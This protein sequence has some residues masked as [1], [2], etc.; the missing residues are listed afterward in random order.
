M[1]QCPKFYRFILS[2]YVAMMCH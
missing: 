2:S 1:V